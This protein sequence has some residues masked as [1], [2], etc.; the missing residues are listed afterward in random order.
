MIRIIFG[1]ENE[2]IVDKDKERK[3]NHQGVREKYHDDLT[4]NPMD[5]P[6]VFLLHL[7]QQ[8]APLYYL[9]T[10]ASAVPRDILIAFD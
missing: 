4:N 5:H 9:P 7:H 6:L 3:T 1:L 8:G 10:A 2:W